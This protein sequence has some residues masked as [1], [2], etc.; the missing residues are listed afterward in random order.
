MFKLGKIPKGFYYIWSGSIGTKQRNSHWKPPAFM[1]VFYSCSLDD[2]FVLINPRT[3][4]HSLP[5][6]KQYQIK[7]YPTVIF[8]ELGELCKDLDPLNNCTLDIRDEVVEYLVHMASLCFW[9]RCSLHTQGH[10]HFRRLYCRSGQG[11]WGSCSF[12]VNLPWLINPPLLWIVTVPQAGPGIPGKEHYT[13]LQEGT[14]TQ[15]KPPPPRNQIHP[16][17]WGPSGCW[18]CSEMA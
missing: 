10:D 1:T 3:I 4:S 14:R 15:Q 11:T 18:M 5:L 8:S 9:A 6:T 7:S 16:Y 12:C 17:P 13:G 2:W